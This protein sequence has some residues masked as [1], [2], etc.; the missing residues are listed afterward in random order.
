MIDSQMT[1]PIPELPAA[2]HRSRLGI[3]SLSIAL[4]V[5]AILIVSIVV[6]MLLDSR[7]KTP[8]TVIG[9]IAVV[10]GLV[11]PLLYITG[12]TFGLNRLDL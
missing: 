9:I 10:L 11:S 5:P 4:A 1:N 8:R 3:A 12:G 6:G 7:L 2:K